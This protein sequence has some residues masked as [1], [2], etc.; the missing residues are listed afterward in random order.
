MIL[1]LNWDDSLMVGRKSPPSVDACLSIV[2]LGDIGYMVVFVILGKE[3][4]VCRAATC[5]D[6]IRCLLVLS[7]SSA[8]SKL[9]LMR[10]SG[11]DSDGN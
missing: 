1:V 2:G 6:R 8:V 11:D 10:V 5:G 7:R 3:D 4:S 9:R